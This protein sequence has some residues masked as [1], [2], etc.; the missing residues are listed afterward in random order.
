MKIIR[1]VIL[2]ALVLA[3]L[4]SCSPS[5]NVERGATPWSGRLADLRVQWDAGPGIDLLTGASVPVRAY[6]ESRLL[7]QYSGEIDKTYAGF[8]EAVPPNE[9][10]TS[11]DMAAWD[12]RPPLNYPATSS[13]VG[14]IRFH[15]ISVVS[16]I[17]HLSVT[18][19]N[20]I[21]NAAQE[22]A[23]G[24]FVS[25]VDWGPAEERG[26]S[27]VRVFLRGPSTPSREL[28]PQTGSQPS[29]AEDVF[30]NWTITGFL[31][32]A[33]TSPIVQWPNFEADRASCVANAPDP[34]SRRKELT[35]GA[36]P[37]SEFPTSAPRPGWPET[38]KE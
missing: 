3:A 5:P 15:I 32:A 21:Y 17:D 8:L 14:N 16:G 34:L 7:A 10:T 29:P 12:R 36:H 37:R 18:V 2:V 19:C 26:I 20:Y 25:L 28:V 1:R 6:L 13:L 27:A 31:V 35:S 38:P 9:P 23:D 30:G 22:Q 24:T 4:P 33:G 11:P